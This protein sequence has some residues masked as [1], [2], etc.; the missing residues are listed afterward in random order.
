MKE[1]FK[2]KIE[3]YF[4]KL[5][6]ANETVKKLKDL[7][8]KHAYVD[9]NDHYNED[10]NIHT[11]LPGTETSVSLSGLVLESGA[12]GIVRD[13]APLNAASPMVSGFGKFEEVTDINCKVVVQIEEGDV[14]RIKQIIKDMG[15]D[16]DNPNVEKPGIEKDEESNIYNSLNETSK[17]I[18]RE[19][20]GNL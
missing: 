14:S 1:G 18:D 10:R 3:G 9:N 4:G 5:K 8:F 20:K 12:H 11:N 13:K 19:L 6:A 7:G 16:L 15:G 2:I 17:F